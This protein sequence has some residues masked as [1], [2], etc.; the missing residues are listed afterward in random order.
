MIEWSAA[1]QA[2]LVRLHK[3]LDDVSPNA[4][5]RLVRSLVAAPQRLA[6]HPRLG[7]R[8]ALYEPREVRRIFVAR[9]EMRYEVRGER[10]LIVRVWHAREDR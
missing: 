5:A 10:I 9:C 2:D 7:E 8:L 6:D 1:A 4:A 3:F